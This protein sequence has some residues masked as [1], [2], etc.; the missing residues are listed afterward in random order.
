MP[1]EES[2]LVDL[3]KKFTGHTFTYIV[4]AAVQAVMSVAGVIVFTRVF[5]PDAYGH[6]A[7]AWST[8]TI[9]L[10]GAS[11]WILQTTIRY[12]TEYARDGQLDFFN[13]NLLLLLISVSALLLLLSAAV[14]PWVRELGGFFLP[15]VVCI[16]ASFWYYNLNYIFMADLQPKRFIFFSCAYSVLGLIIALVWVYV[17]KRDVT[18]ILWG[19]S[20]AALIL[21]AP[22]LWKTHIFYP[23]PVNREP[24]TRE[25]FAVF[26]KKSASY[27]L[28]LIGWFLGAS[29]L[30]ISDR[31]FIQAFRGS[32]E[33]GL[34][35]PNYDLAMKVFTFISLPIIY[36]AHSI[37]MNVAA[38]DSEDKSATRQTISVFSRYYLIVSIPVL[39]FVAI[40]AKDIMRIFLGQQFREGYVIVPIILLGYF[41]WNFALYGHKGLELSER[42]RT[43]LLYVILCLG[44]NVVLNFIFVPWLGYIG[45]AITSLISLAAYPVLV[46]FGT[47]KIMPWQIPWRDFVKIAFAGGIMAAVLLPIR[48]FIL[49]DKPIAGVIVGLVVGTLVFGISLLVVKEMRPFELSYL[50]RLLSVRALTSKRAN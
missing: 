34:Y 38:S 9:I 8:V 27:G 41:L 45:A 20:L 25:Q 44:M 37:L 6:Y 24:V 21:I 40:F 42:T 18:G 23:R 2:E 32:Y 17:F 26:A 5:A 48:L 7:L 22:L 50:R 3:T 28:P 19:T 10:L 36:A 43:M 4:G 46:Y 13:R 47:R 12:R 35:S 14:L 15:A 31:F 33:V 11:N 49:W 30:D 1:L 16:L 39:V 29:L